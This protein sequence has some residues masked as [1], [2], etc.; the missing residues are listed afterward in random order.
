M[1]T[2]APRQA[3]QNQAKA[4]GTAA[5]VPSMTG[6]TAAIHSA[7]STA[8]RRGASRR[9]RTPAR[10][11]ATKWVAAAPASSQPTCASDVPSRSTKNAPEK[12]SKAVQPV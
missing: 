5:R 2:P 9:P 4:H 3:T 11:E 10:L 8:S 1:R 7:P 6:V 12:V